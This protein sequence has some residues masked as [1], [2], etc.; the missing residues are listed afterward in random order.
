MLM[1]YLSF[2]TMSRKIFIIVKNSSK[3]F[4]K[5]KLVIQINK[6]LY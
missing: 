4:N 2:E 1:F 6:E 3:H 5:A